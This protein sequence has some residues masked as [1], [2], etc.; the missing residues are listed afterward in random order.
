[1][2]LRSAGGIGLVG[3]L[4]AWHLCLVGMVETF[5]ERSL[6][7][8]EI[9]L[10]YILLAALILFVGFMAA[11]KAPIPTVA[12][13]G[14]AVAGVVVGLALSI[15]AFLSDTFSIRDMFIFASREL[16]DI[17]TFE[18]GGGV[19]L[20]FPVALGAVF[21]LIGASLTLLGSQWR[22]LIT[23]ALIGVVLLGLLRDVITAVLPRNINRTL[24]TNSGLTITG[25][26]VALALTV[27]VAFIVSAYRR[28]NIS[29]NRTW[30]VG[31]RQINPK[32]TI[33]LTLFAVF[34]I[35][36]PLWS[37]LF[38]S[39]VAAFIGLYIIMGLGLN[40]V[41]GFAGLLDL[42]YAG[43]FAVGAYAMAFLTSTDL[44]FYNLSFWQALP[45][46]MLIAMFA[47]LLLGLPVLRMRGDYLAITTLG[48]GE[49][50]RLLA[51]S[52][53]LKPYLGGARG[54]TRI[55]YPSIGDFLIDSPQEFYYMILVGV[56]LAW[57]IATRLKTSR[58]GRAWMAVRE[59]EDVAQAMGVNRVNAKLSAFA[60]GALLGGMSGAIFASMVN[61]VVPNSFGLLVSINVLSLIIVG[62]MGSLPGVLVGALVLVGLPEL[63]REF[64]EYRLLVYGAIL[65]LMM[66]Y[67]PEGLW[68]EATVA[69]EL[70]AE[71][72]A[73]VDD[74]APIPV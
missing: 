44:G 58:L 61:S 37:S 8:R 71:E 36:F 48:F 11:R 56:L 22:R 27:A 64:N 47:G 26:V 41:V 49:I 40:L 67:R 72:A 55:A 21:G 59:D 23:I 73:P 60:L 9:S 25:A 6:I 15:L 51:L 70:H 32:Q 24:F 19:G 29:A 68:P 14:G 63:L 33:A 34:L 50:I 35:S 43:F 12:L 18:Q 69:R 13:S 5:A 65:V 10:G 30:S 66:L 42:G 4:V 54:V 46:A 62:G 16:V 1:M 38:L 53:W 20:L 28:S 7:G 31:G 52:E 57:F 17:L 45:I 2:A 3:A 39:N 74:E